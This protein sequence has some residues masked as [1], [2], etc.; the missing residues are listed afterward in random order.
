MEEVGAAQ[1]AEDEVTI[2]GSRS[3]VQGVIRSPGR[4][5]PVADV[6]QLGGKT[7]GARGSRWTGLCDPQVSTGLLGELA[8]KPARR[9]PGGRQNW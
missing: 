8:R 1:G 5:E 6:L 7:G 3:S 2:S 4:K 9:R